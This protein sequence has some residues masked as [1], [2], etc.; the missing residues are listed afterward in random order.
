MR[1]IKNIIAM[2][3][4]I[5][6][7]SACTH[8]IL[9]PEQ[10][11]YQTATRHGRQVA[12]M[13]IQV[14]TRDN[15]L[16]DKS[17]GYANY[18]E[19]ILIDPYT[20][21]DWASITK[22]LVWIAI[23]QLAEQGKLDLNADIRNYISYEVLTGLRYPITVN[24]LITHSSGWLRSDI[25]WPHF[26]VQGEGAEQISLGHFLRGTEIVQRFTPGEVPTYSFHNL[27]LASYIAEQI[28]GI[29]FYEYVHRYIFTPLNMNQTALRGD[30]SDNI[31][32]KNQR[33]HII[34]YL[35]A[36]RL[37]TFE[38][39]RTNLTIDMAIGTISDLR[40]LALAIL[41]DENGSSVLFEDAETLS[42]L[43]YSF[44]YEESAFIDNENGLLALNGMMGCISTLLI[45]LNRGMGVI[46]MVNHRSE[47][48]FNRVS[49]LREILD[50][51]E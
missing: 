37:D 31:W 29:A 20:V 21:F 25:S 26:G 28:S 51:F 7:M 9:S 8:D 43:L 49:F 35:S 50:R 46:V 40:M 47:P 11:V 19:G 3:T 12:G 30:L 45:C 10:F 2:F 5:S 1:Y 38:W 15:L 42:K 22:P 24:H 18:A 27:V 13:N 39:L 23:L 34:C 17:F 41:P 36:D 33:E 16:L 48:I 4:L 44:A 6:L 32:V 14:F